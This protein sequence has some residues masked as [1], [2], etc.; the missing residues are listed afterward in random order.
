LA[1]SSVGIVGLLEGR[2]GMCGGSGKHVH[3]T[4]SRKSSSGEA[5]AAP[6]CACGGYGRRGGGRC[7][8]R[9]GALPCG[10]APGRAE[11]GGTGARAE[12]RRHRDIIAA[13]HQPPTI[14][15]SRVE[16]SASSGHL[17]GRRMS[18]RCSKR[19]SSGSILPAV[20]SCSQGRHPCPLDSTSV[21]LV[22]P[23]QFL[24]IQAGPTMSPASHS[25]VLYDG[26]SPWSV[27]GCDAV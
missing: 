18:V 15:Q 24:L 19:R 5:A 14:L 3:V 12:K 1:S 7:V 25:A 13:I 9:S 2:C 8:T 11:G 10:G 27:I 4:A 22:L 23:R 21:E 26:I 6:G 20:V 16:K 17:Q